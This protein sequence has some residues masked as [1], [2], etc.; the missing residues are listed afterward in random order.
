MWY[1]PLTAAAACLSLFLDNNPPPT[2]THKHPQVMLV[3]RLRHRKSYPWS[4]YAE[5][6]CIT[7]GVAIFS[8]SEKQPKAGGCVRGNK[9]DRGDGTTTMTDRTVPCRAVHTYILTINQNQPNNKTTNQ[10]TNQGKPAR[11]RRWGTCCWPC[12]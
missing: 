10:P 2:H 3:G 7:L 12:T 6:A 1:K 4:E 11:T 8:L 9:T 5:A